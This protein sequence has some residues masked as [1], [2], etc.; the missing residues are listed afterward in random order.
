MKIGVSA[1]AWTSV[2]TERHLSVLPALRGNGIAALEIPM[3]EPSH[4]PAKAIRD[5]C[6]QHE[7]VPTVCAILPPGINPISPEPMVRRQSQEHLRQCVAVAAEMGASLLGGPLCAPIGYLPEHRPT[8][9][10]WTRAVDAFQ[11]L[12]ESLDSYAMT[13]SMEPVNRAETF[14]LR[15]AAQARALCEAVNHPRIGVTIDTF[16]AN[17][18]EKNIAQAVQSLGPHL[19]HLHLS[20]NDRSLLGAGHVDFPSILNAAA[21]IGYSGYLMIEGFGYSPE[22]QFGPGVLWAE[23]HVSPE[24]LAYESATYLRS[25]LRMQAIA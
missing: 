20:E 25:L 16:H 5:A 23:P 1:F 24:A 19:K 21:S 14:F 7:I 13:I 17:I 22:E 2:F 9:D 15:T 6:G 8:A 11:Q 18:E 4:L 10:E 3:L 12:G